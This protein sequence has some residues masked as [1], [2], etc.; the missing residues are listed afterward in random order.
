MRAHQGAYFTCSEH[1]PSLGGVPGKCHKQT[2]L[3]LTAMCASKGETLKEK[4][5]AKYAPFP[6][7]ERETE[8]SKQKRS[9]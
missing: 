1:G 6:S 5:L 2:Q 8:T 3:K 9:G 4:G 7:K